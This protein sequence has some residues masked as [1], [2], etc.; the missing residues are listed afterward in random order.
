MWL[1]KSLLQDLF[2]RQCP[3][4]TIAIFDGVAV[5]A[6]WVQVNNLLRICLHLVALEEYNF[7]WYVEEWPLLKRLSLNTARCRLL[8]VLAIRK[9]RPQSSGLF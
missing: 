5:P 6:V 8:P 4:L 2:V 1:E 3:A 9:D 7:K